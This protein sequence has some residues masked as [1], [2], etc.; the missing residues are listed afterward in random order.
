MRILAKNKYMIHIKHING[1]KKWHAATLLTSAK[2]SKCEGANAVYSDLRD[3]SNF[4]YKLK[5]K[6]TKLQF[7]IK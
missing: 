2:V 3:V 1:T 4:N 7:R 6:L 5:C